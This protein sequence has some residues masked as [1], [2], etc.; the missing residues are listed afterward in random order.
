MHIPGLIECFL[1]LYKF[2]QSVFTVPCFGKKAPLF[3][4]NVS[5][6]RSAHAQ[7]LST[8]LMSL[9]MPSPLFAS[10]N[11]TGGVLASKRGAAASARF[12]HARFAT[13]CCAFQNTFYPVLAHF[14]T[15]SI[16]GF[17]PGGWVGRGGTQERCTG[18]K[19]KLT[20]QNCLQMNELSRGS[21][22]VFDG[23]YG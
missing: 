7:S 6:S 3:P 18:S 1:N 15:F 4:S 22:G 2:C 13:F 20:P 19:Q 17:L 8:R 23:E 9:P 12:F 16:A 5:S 10:N 21:F 11:N 14:S